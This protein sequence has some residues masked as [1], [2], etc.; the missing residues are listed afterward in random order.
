VY[1]EVPHDLWGNE[2]TVSPVSRRDGQSVLL[3]P[4]F[5]EAV[6]L[7]RRA[8][9]PIIFI[10]T[11]AAR[12]NL[13]TE[14]TALAEALSAPVVG[15]TAAKG[16]LAEDHPLSFGNAARGWWSKISCRIVTSPW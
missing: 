13:A 7:L 1:V 9:Q 15:S 8:K 14:I 2:V 5:D 10:G 3:P 11:D 4:R 12:A 16:V 6:T